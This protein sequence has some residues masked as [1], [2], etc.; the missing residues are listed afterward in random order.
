MLKKN[1]L[2]QKR[3][4]RIRKSVVGTA[5]RPRL[6]LR[7]SGKHIYAQCVDDDAGR[8]LA[9]LSTLDKDLRAQKLSANLKGAAY[10]AQA[11]AEKAKAAGITQV[12]FDRNGRRYHGCVKVFADAVREAGIKF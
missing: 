1:D 3:R 5:E 11:F 8:T 12:V 7:L 4:W 9:F 10:A 2:L 6:S